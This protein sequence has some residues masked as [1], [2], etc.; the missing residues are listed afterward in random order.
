M[1]QKK[2][3]LEVKFMMCSKHG[4]LEPIST[5]SKNKKGEYYKTCDHHR[6][7]MKSYDDTHAGKR[8]DYRETHANEKKIYNEKYKRGDDIRTILI[9]KILSLLRK[10]RVTHRPYNDDNKITIEYV[11]ELY[12]Q[13]PNYKCRYC[14]IEMVT[15]NFE[16][17]QIDQISINRLDNSLAHIKGN[18]EFCCYFCNSQRQ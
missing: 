7:C 6:T 13:L 18:V 5:F 8:K 3:K 2:I 10:D 17:H 1:E 9:A 15:A 14:G 11:L 16:K 12:N 4:N